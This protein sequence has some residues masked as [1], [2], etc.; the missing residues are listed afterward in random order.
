M[1]GRRACLDKAVHGFRLLLGIQ[2]RED[3]GEQEGGCREGE[4]VSYM[5]HLTVLSILPDLPDHFP[6]HT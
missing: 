1:C 2:E 6:L 3:D 4:G 5:L